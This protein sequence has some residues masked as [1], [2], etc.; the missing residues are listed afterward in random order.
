MEFIE[1]PVSAVLKLWHMALT[2]LGM[3][4]VPAWTLS[5]V[6]LV[7]TVRLI[8]LPFAYRAY[9]STRVLVNLRPALSALDAQYADRFSSA[10]RRELL[11]KR[12]ELQRSEG[13]R[14]R[15]GCAPILIQFP[16]FIGLYRILLNVSRPKDLEADTHPGIGAL[17]AD[18][19][20]HFLDAEIFGIP[21]SAYNA[22][23]EDRLAFLGTTGEEVFRFALPLCIAAAVFTTTNMAYSIYRNWM[24][25]DENNATARVM[26]R[27]MFI[28]AGVAVSVPLLFGLLGPAPVAILCYWVMNNLWTMVQNVSLHLILDRQVPYTEEF[29]EHR[30]SVGHNRKAKQVELRD[31]QKEL[32]KRSAERKSRIKELNHT[33]S[34]SA[35]DEVREEAREEKEALLDE[36]AVD[37]TEVEELLNRDKRVKEERKAKQ[38]QVQKKERAQRRAAKAE[39]AAKAPKT[40]AEEAKTEKTAEDHE[41]ADSARS[42]SP[43][44]SATSSETDIDSPADTDSSA[45]G[46]TVGDK[47]KPVSPPPAVEKPYE[48]RHRLGN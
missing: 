7:V 47:P 28:L 44:T 45:S 38:R 20:N 32:K 5:I 16:V 1:Y 29:R 18:D 34:R 31:A 3:S 33:I 25:L 8:L 41:K 24:T 21:L 35:S 22:M 27:I 14:M 37:R 26:F 30:R 36:D 48:G 15:D 2:A 9:R 46:D 19:V 4:E 42:E 10:D 23:A 13:Y 11:A 6:L 12:R 39:K 40:T 17:S 43:K